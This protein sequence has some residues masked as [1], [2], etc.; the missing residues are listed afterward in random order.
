MRNIHSSGHG[1]APS[2][3]QDCG[4]VSNYETMFRM[5]EM[6]LHIYVTIEVYG[7]F[8]LCTFDNCLP[9]QWWQIY[10][11][12]LAKIRQSQKSIC[13]QN[14]LSNPTGWKINI[15]SLP[16]IF[17]GIHVSACIR[18]DHLQC[19]VHL[20]LVE[21]SLFC[22]CIFLIV[23][24]LAAIYVCCIFLHFSAFSL[25]RAIK[26]RPTLTFN[27]DSKWRPTTDAT[28]T[29]TLV[30]LVSKCLGSHCHTLSHIVTLSR[31]HIFIHCHIFTL[32][33]VVGNR[34]EWKTLKLEK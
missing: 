8:W 2:I 21:F 18:R 6:T 34:A 7:T 17:L 9:L 24:F 3:G 5:C 29:L 31:C 32:L 14:R 1:F 28:F 13:R 26:L 23:F 11:T 20:L 16:H 25:Q 19:G 30:L 33:L 12:T 22:F 4:F 27:A 15:I 10:Q